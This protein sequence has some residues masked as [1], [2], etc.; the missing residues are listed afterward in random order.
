MRVLAV[1]TALPRTEADVVGIFIRREVY[2]LRELGLE[3]RTFEARYRHGPM[4][5]VRALRARIGEIAPDLVHVYA[6]SIG[7]LCASLVSPVPVV[8]TFTGSDLLGA[9]RDDPFGERMVC[10]ASVLFSQWAARRAA[11][12]IVCSQELRAALWRRKDRERAHVIP[13]GVN[14]DLFQPQDRRS[15]RREIA[16]PEEGRVVLFGG[17][18]RRPVKRFGLAEA[19]MRRLRA[20]G[21]EARLESLEDV[22]P[23]RVPLHLCAADCLLLTS[24]HEGSPNVV[25][26]A[27][28]CACP[29]VGVPVGDVREILDGVEPGAVVEGDAETLARALAEVLRDGR[30]ANGV[31]RIRERHSAR[32][33]AARIR[34]VYRDVLGGL[35]QGAGA[36]DGEGQPC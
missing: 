35:G 19:A 18:R 32:A 1:A 5:A 23:D 2:A 21:V 31:S 17:S 25:K 27:V 22:P 9:A 29:V 15:A 24:Q 11:A 34:A 16:W 36:A 6:G 20:L 26:E 7:A 12:L 4:R 30:R 14:V 3:V 13:A 28:A 10:R 33:A 8:V